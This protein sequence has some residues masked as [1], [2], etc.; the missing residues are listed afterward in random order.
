MTNSYVVI[1]CLKGLK[2][3][4]NNSVQCII[5]SPPYNKLGLREGTPYLNQIIYDNFDDNID[6]DDYQE[7]QRQ[8][9]NE[10]NR[11]LKPNGSC[12]YNHKD[13]RYKNVDYP[14]EAFVL[15]SDLRLYQTIIW[16]RG[17]T[18]NQN[19]SYFRP[20][21]EKIFW[22]TKS[23]S[24]RSRPKFYRNRLPESFKTSIWRINRER[25]S[26]HPA[27]FPSILAEIC[28]VATTDEGKRSRQ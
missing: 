13:R 22:L 24:E 26:D 17:N 10:I 9:L 12:F 27:P 1:D 15:Q 8:I 2:L 6:E 4:P 16:D 25:N 7:W 21:Y 18:P 11:V 14:P 20:N 19:H 5:T 28:L 23:S 3:L